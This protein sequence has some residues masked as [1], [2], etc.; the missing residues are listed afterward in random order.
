VRLSKNENVVILKQQV[1]KFTLVVL[2][3][4]FRSIGKHSLVQTFRCPRNQNE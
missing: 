2:K 4:N 1:G 3:Y